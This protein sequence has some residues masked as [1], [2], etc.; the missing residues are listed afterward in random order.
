M[1]GSYSMSKGKCPKDLREK[2]LQAYRFLK[3]GQDI[4]TESASGIIYRTQSEDSELT[5]T[6]AGL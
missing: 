3:K 6:E 5:T 2:G 4:R 1:N